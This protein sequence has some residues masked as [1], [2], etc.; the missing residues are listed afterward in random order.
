MVKAEFE[1]Q[2]AKA[3]SWDRQI[4]D[5]R[6]LILNGHEQIQPAPANIKDR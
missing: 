4:S 1:K 6:S 2:K 5:G 3:L